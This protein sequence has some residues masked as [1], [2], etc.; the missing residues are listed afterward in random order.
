MTEE[1]DIAM[2]LG[3]AFQV[4]PTAF[5][6]LVTCLPMAVF[7]EYIDKLIASAVGSMLPQ[8]RY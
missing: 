1:I 3:L 8:A 5:S 6:A 7:V 2:W 4:H